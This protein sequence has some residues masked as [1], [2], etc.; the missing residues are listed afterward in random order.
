MVWGGLRGAVGLALAIVVDRELNTPGGLMYD[1]LAGTLILF[2][3]GGVA[4]LTLLINAPLSP[5]V[6]RSLGMMDV[7]SE[8]KKIMRMNVRQR[9]VAKAK[10]AYAKHVDEPRFQGHDEEQVKKLCPMLGEDAAAPHASAAD[11]DAHS[12]AARAWKSVLPKA[13]ANTRRETPSAVDMERNDQALLKHLRHVFLSVVRTSYW[14][15]LEQHL[16]PPNSTAAT[17]LI[18]SIDVA[19]DFA[20][21]PL[22]DWH[23]VCMRECMRDWHAVCACFAIFLA[24]SFSLLLSRLLVL[25]RAHPFACSYPFACS[26]PFAC[27]YP[28]ACSHP[29]ACSYPFACS[30]SI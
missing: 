2:H 28:F 22:C 5:W 6:L 29:F 9:V 3:V 10:E 24:P 18:A 8:A 30:F 21:Q 17:V 12:R 19:Q 7:D 11:E 23:E 14:E 25:V 27:S 26:H 4:T 13:D 1:P 16:L 15:Y 20:H